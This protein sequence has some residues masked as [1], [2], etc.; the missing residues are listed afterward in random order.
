MK[1]IICQTIGNKASILQPKTT[2]IIG[3][4]KMRGQLIFL[5]IIEERTKM[6]DI[7]TKKRMILRL[8]GDHSM[9]YLL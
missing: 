2:L 6:I 7:T 5:S 1:V 4:N 9:S 8:D 3:D